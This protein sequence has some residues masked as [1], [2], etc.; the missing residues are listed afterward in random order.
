MSLHLLPRL[1]RI[2]PW[3]A[4]AGLLAAACGLPLPAAGSESTLLKL[5]NHGQI[6]L[7]AQDDALPLS[8]LH[9][10]EHLGFHMELCQRIVASLRLRFDLP[11][12]RAVTVTTTQ[13]TRLAMLHNGTID[14][15]CGH[16][17]V[18]GAPGAQRLFSHATLVM[19]M[20]LLAGR[21][22]PAWTLRELEGKRV[23]TAVGGTALARLRAVARL[24]NQRIVPVPGR[25]LTEM[26][27]QLRNGQVDLIIESEPY[28]QA[29]RV[30]SD[31]PDRYR[32]LD[33][34]LGADP[35]ALM[36]RASD[37]ALVGLANE[38][39]AGMMR[40]GEME[41]LYRKWFV[42][43]IPGLPTGLGWELQPATRALYADPG[44][45]ARQF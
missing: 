14:M 18:T 43:P 36:F 39:I 27:E 44:S 2:G 28:L 7:G 21:E 20:G 35:V 11:R 40:N 30:G 17:P 37:E 34:R 29:Q 23:A 24:Q 33:D 9:D 1:P 5:A 22:G 19:P 13:A 38:V 31:H 10:N 12:L 16:N 26:F 4:A 3:L 8:Y 42:L 15:A 41:R 32:L 45:E 6:S 25:S